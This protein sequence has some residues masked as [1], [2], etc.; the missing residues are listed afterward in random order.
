MKRALFG[1][2]QRLSSLKCGAWACIASG[3]LLSATG[4]HAQVESLEPNP[5]EPAGAGAANVLEFRGGSS[6]GAHLGRAPRGESRGA[7]RTKRQ[8]WF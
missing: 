3:A 1:T 4:L 2:S 8:Q 5:L 6:A 7:V